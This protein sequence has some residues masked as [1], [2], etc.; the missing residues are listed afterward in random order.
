[1][2]YMFTFLT[3][4]SPKD[5]EL[6]LIDKIAPAETGALIKITLRYPISRFGLV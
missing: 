1:M 3:T 2:P 6:R 5:G 4:P